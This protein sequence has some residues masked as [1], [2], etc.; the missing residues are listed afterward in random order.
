M[1]PEAHPSLP[2]R[3]Q[4]VIVGGGVIG[5]SIAYH[6]TKL[7]VRDVLLLEK[8]EL[9]AGTT[10]H[11]AGLITSAG[12]HDEASLWMCRYSRDLY[13]RLEQETGHSTGFRPVGHLSVATTPER[14]ETLVRERD[15]QVGFGVPNQ[16]IGPAEVAEL[17]P[18]ARIDD[19]VGA[20]YVT[21]EGRA[22]PVGVATSLAKGARQGGATIVEG[23]TVTGFT[24]AGRRVTGVVTSAGTVEAETVVLSAGL[25]SRQ[26]ARTIGVDVPLQA[27]EHYYLLTEPMPGVHADL[28]IIEDLQSYGYYREEGGG[29][30]VGLFEPVAAAWHP[31]GAPLDFAF[32]TIPADWDRMTPHLETA[33]ARIPSLSEAGI[34]TFFC[35][36]ESFTSDVAPLLGPAPEVDGLFVAAGLNSV[37][38]LLGG[39]VGSV[40]ATWIVDGICPVDTAGLTIER[41][42][43]FEGTRRFRSE[44][45]VEQLGVLFGDGSFPT[46]HQ[47]S[48]RGIRRSP[49]HEVWARKG[50]YFAVSAGWEYPEWF[51]PTGANPPVPWTWGRGY[52]TP[53]IAEEHR[54]VREA[55]GVMDMT[56]MSKF[57]VQGPHA[58]DILDRLSANAVVGDIGK[59]T[60]TQWCN[61][62]GG[63]EADLTV[64]RLAEDRFLVVVSDVTHRR[65]ERM[66]NA[67]LRAGEFAT[68]TDLTGG[69]AILTV[70]GPRSRELLTRVSPDD[71][72]NEGFPYLTAREIE[73]GY[74]RVL[75][76]RVTYLGELGFELYVPA[77]QAVSVWETLEAAGAD[78]GL[79]PV[80][81]G[82]LHS[83]R[84]EKGYRDYG[85]DIDVTDTPVSAGLSFAVAWDK[86]TPFRGKAALEKLRGDRTSRLVNVL[87][88]SPEPLLH[89]SEAVLKDGSWVGYVQVGG[90]GHTLGASLGL[91]S[92]DHAEGIT[93]EWLASG[94]F[95]V[96]VA[97][98]PYPATL[99]FRPLYDPDRAR[100][101]C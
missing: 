36:P 38:I 86:P 97:G 31:E 29:L 7:G 19:L 92:I 51:S 55:V 88:H 5:C 6:L 39:G 63:I 49:L 45:I 40:M 15:F 24:R 33:M 91:A 34:R 70:Q 96:V 54:T 98:V 66:L 81:L 28:P 84:L 69:L 25:W 37:G 42:L 76:L 82:A 68:V 80:G 12:Y 32:G 46:F 87:L 8:H 20:S 93:A 41:A 48:A 53:W 1:P 9:T 10:W 71:L 61:D 78:L 89:G 52:W 77:D 18:L 27:A 23:V 3:A 72:T 65:V 14:M 47:H 67:E 35:G 73:V 57:L 17:F 100:I 22:D 79:R 43:P 58:A 83:L 4:V 26:M 74:S 101:L 85:I 75:A 95:E 62:R 21:D 59:V 94:G 90:F 99:Q 50:A 2:S 44:R 64:T 56:V 60:Y 30:L 11:A 13:S 16:I